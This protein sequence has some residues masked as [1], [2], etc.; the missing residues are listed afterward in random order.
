MFVE[1][2]KKYD[3]YSEEELEEENNVAAGEELGVEYFDKFPTRSKLAYHKYLMCVPIPSLF[4]RNPTIVGGSPLNHKIPC[5][6]GH[7]H[8]WKAYIDLNSSINIMTC[9]QYNWIMRKQLEPRDDPESL[10]GISNFTGRV[11]GMHIF[12]GNFTYVLDFLIVEDISSVI[13]PSLSHV[14]LEKPF[15]EVSN[16]TYDSSLGIVKFTNGTDKIAY[17]MPY[18]IEHFKSLSN[19]DKEHK[20]SVYFRSEEDKRRGVDYVM[21]KIL[22]FYKECLEL[23]PK[24]LTRLD[25][26]RTIDGVT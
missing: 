11:R 7:I 14:V 24:Y 23:G 5:N 12:L 2:I 1:L 19:M 6:I 4:I 21:N 18:K 25:G 26:S 3:D 9:T 22:G 17:M 16:M 13:D 20:Q 8:V 10:R 15:V